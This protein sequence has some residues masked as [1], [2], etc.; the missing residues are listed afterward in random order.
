[1]SVDEL[2]I[3][4]AEVVE[5]DKPATQESVVY[6]PRKPEEIKNHEQF[7]NLQVIFRKLD[8]DALNPK[9]FAVN[10]AAALG[11]L[12]VLASSLGLGFDM[13]KPLKHGMLASS[14]TAGLYSAY[15]TRKLEECLSVAELSLL[16]GL[17]GSRRTV[18]EYYRAITSPAALS[19]AM[20][21]AESEETVE[22]LLETYN[23]FDWK[24]WL[25]GATSAILLG[26]AG[27]AKSVSAKFLLGEFDIPFRLVIMDIHNEPDSYPESLR[28]YILGTKDQIIDYIKWFLEVE[29]PTRLKRLRNG[30][31]DENVFLINYLEEVGNLVNF[32]N[33]DEKEQVKKF[34]VSAISTRKLN[35]F[36]LL[37][38]QIKNTKG[39]AISGIGDVLES[40]S[41]VIMGKNAIKWAKIAGVSKL[42]RKMFLASKKYNCLVDNEYIVKHPTHGHYEKVKKGLPPANLEKFEQLTILD[43]SE[44]LALF[45]EYESTKVETENG[46]YEDYVYIRNQR[47]A[48]ES[49]QTIL[50]TLWGVNTNWA[51][52]NRKN[53][54]KS[55]QLALADK[56]L[57]DWVDYLVAQG[58]TDVARLTE[59]TYGKST[60]AHKIEEYLKGKNV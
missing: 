60:F 59:L 24:D 32:C 52:T 26:N 16:E 7:K 41:Q 3:I 38:N 56:Y 13:P 46:D 35:V 23:K 25:D 58:I 6:I 43:W 9:Y 47:L 49:W 48:G 12:T 5:D 55:R 19:Q 28:P 11:S 1:M 27:S 15:K 4:D 36:N 14:V 17:D 18:E 39:N 50:Q 40:Y 34:I 45:G 22:E 21:L 53:S 10:C 31:K 54:H 37:V 29:E 20:S 33:D 8:I 51:K 57:S 30:Q 44:F 42:A 2:E